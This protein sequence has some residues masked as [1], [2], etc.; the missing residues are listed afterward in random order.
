MGKLAAGAT[1]SKATVS[2]GDG[3]SRYRIALRGGLD[4]SWLAWLD[5]V[6]IESGG[7]VTVLVVTVAD[8]VAL[9]GLLSQ[10]WDL[11][12]TVISVNPA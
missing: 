11:N 10:L 9:R 8:Q 1:G 4:R 2:A 12:L 7:D 5:E 3:P 6:A